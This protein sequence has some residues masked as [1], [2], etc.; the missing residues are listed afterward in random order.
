MTKNKV[1]KKM[2]AVLAFEAF[3]TMQ[4]I[5]ETSKRIACLP[6]RAR[7]EWA[8]KEILSYVKETEKDVEYSMIH[9]GKAAHEFLKLLNL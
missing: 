4:D 7:C 2:A 1:K 8:K 3:S 5:E 6:S 9:V